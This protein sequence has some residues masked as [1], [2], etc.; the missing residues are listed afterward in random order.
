MISRLFRNKFEIKLLQ[1]DNPFIILSPNHLSSEDEL[2]WIDVSYD[3]S[4]EK[5]D[6]MP[7]TLNRMNG[8]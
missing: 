7:Q 1:Y 4:L 6:A 3:Q 5:E 2:K 8:V